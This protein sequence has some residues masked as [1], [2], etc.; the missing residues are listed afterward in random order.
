MTFWD[1]NATPAGVFNVGDMYHTYT[2]RQAIFIVEQLAIDV[3]QLKVEAGIV[4]DI[5]CGIGRLTFEV[6]HEAP[7]LDVVGV[8]PSPS[9]IEV[10]RE[11]LAENDYLINHRVDFAETS[12]GP[13]L[14][15]G[16]DGA[17]CVL[18]FQHLPDDTVKQHLADLFEI[19]KPGARL[20]TQWVTRG[21]EGPMSYPRRRATILNW[22]AAAGFGSDGYILFGDA[23]V[24]GYSDDWMWVVAEKPA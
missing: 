22:H 1:D 15:G 11:R 13:L 7:Y 4:A 23:L 8:D 21:E 17:W 14:S 6:A 12:D 10:A 9:M 20:V 18:T 2:R 16:Y 3:K 19:L 5:G 24:T